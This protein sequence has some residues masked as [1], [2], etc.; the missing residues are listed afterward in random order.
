MAPTPKY[1][2]ETWIRFKIGPSEA[3][4]QIK[5]AIFSRDAWLYYVTN[6]GSSG[7]PY[8]ITEADIIEV[9]K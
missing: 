1:K 4:G 3:V 2:P 8:A 9:I 6:P 7:T 5:G